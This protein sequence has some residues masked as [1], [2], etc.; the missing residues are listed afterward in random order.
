M[1]FFHVLFSF[2]FSFLSDLE[3]AAAADGAYLAHDDDDDD[4]DDNGGD[5]PSESFPTGRAKSQRCH[6]N[7]NNNNNNNNIDPILFGLQ[8]D[9]F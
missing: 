4:D 5:R 6:N 2:S 3:I 9:Q 7:N 1:D 8:I